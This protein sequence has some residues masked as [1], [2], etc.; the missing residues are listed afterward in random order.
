MDPSWIHGKVRDPR[1]FLDLVAHLDQASARHLWTI[2]LLSETLDAL[3]CFEAQEMADFAK[4]EKW[5][6]HG[7]TWRKHVPN[8]Y[9]NVC[10]CVIFSKRIYIWYISMWIY[11]QIYIYIYVIYKHYVCWT[12]GI[13]DS[14]FKLEMSEQAESVVCPLEMV[15]MYKHD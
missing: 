5:R 7:E 4:G 12:Y 2:L 15:D 9:V 14:S 10:M 3:T 1:C 11:I 13:R 6:E 8:I